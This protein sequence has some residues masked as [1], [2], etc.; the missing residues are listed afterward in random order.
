MKQA[1]VISEF[2][3]LKTVVL[4]QSQ[5]CFPEND[6]G[7]DTSFLT[8]ENEAL[9]KN[10]EGLD[11]AEVDPSLQSAWEQEKMNM[12]ALLEA[13][14]VTVLRPRLLTTVEKEFGKHNGAGYSNFFSRDPFFTIGSFV[15]EGNLRFA[16]R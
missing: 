14:G 16:H 3:P 6:D 15:I 9:A 8:P 10:N 7:A 5:F 2:A 12:Q 11:L 4:A 13:Y 1:K